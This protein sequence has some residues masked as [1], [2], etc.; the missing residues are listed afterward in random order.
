MNSSRFLRF[1]VLTPIL[2]FL[3][4][5][6]WAAESVDTLVKAL[7]SSDAAA[8]DTAAKELGD[9]G[10]AAAPAVEPLRAC[11]KDP[12]ASVRAHSAWALG[13]IGKASMPAIEE[14]AAN[15]TDPNL[16]VRRAAIRALRQIK[17]GQDKVVPLM[18]KTLGDK[19]PAVV[20]MALHTLA[21]GGAAAV[22]AMIEALKDDRT[23]YWACIV[24][25]EI[26]PA[27]K[28]AVPQLIKTLS[29]DEQEVR[30]EG[31]MTLAAIGEAS[32]PAIPK[33]IE[34]L[35]DKETGV[36][37]AAI[38]ALGSLG[39]K[40]D[41]ATTALEPGLQSKDAFVATISTWALARIKS[42]DQ[43][44][45]T[46]LKKDMLPTLFEGVK[47]KNRKLRVAA[48]RA[49]HELK[50]GSEV[51]V[52]A[53]ARLVN[54]NDPVTV[55]NALE[56]I[57]TL[58]DKA[59][60]GL[61]DGLKV[62]GVRG[63]IAEILGRIGEPASPAV[64]AL[65]EAM[66]DDRPEVRREILFALGSIGPQAKAAVGVARK[67]LADPDQTVRYSAVF[68][69][70]RIGSAAAEALPELEK[71]VCDASDPYFGNVCAW[72]L[73]RIDAKNEK[74]V[75]EAIP[76]LIKGLE[77]EK[78]FVRIEAANTLAMIGPP[79]KDALPALKKV[80]ADPDLN[81]AKA[82]VDAIAA[83]SGEPTAS[84]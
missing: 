5:P 40:A 31:A 56:A 27:A 66:E 35:N 16:H 60:P 49:I 10:A 17:P 21:E 14:L 29:D 32:A 64:P 11:L 51:I 7:K 48:V 41:A 4:A 25:S 46:K 9:M 34:L 69:L 6:C 78:S 83:I 52:P 53:F 44:Y 28:D 81:V 42:G 12:D 73:V 50:P 19:E 24:L 2:I 13:Q 84:K 39:P 59:V 58:G 76:V 70:G 71:D 74:R 36:R 54:N 79:A 75:K 1:A 8:R 30:M 3:A 62:K 61:I 80:A 23:D 37:L 43:A 72:A 26:G 82:A 15:L 33:L 20:L 77:N 38:Y 47:D 67:A 68:T 57:A 65:I 63:Q 55:T 22:P 45:L 18:L